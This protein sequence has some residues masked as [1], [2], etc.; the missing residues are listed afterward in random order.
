VGTSPRSPVIFATL[1]TCAIVLSTAALAPL[2][3]QAD[4]TLLNHREWS[5]TKTKVA[6]DLMGAKSYLTGPQALAGSQLNLGAWHGYQEVAL[7]MKVRPETVRFRVWLEENAYLY[8][9]YDR[10]HVVGWEDATWQA[11]R[12]STWPLLPSAQVRA[13]AGGE[14]LEH[15]PLEGIVLREKAWNDVEL[16]FGADTAVLILNKGPA[17]PVGAPILDAFHV[18]FRGGSR[19]A[20]VD[21]IA[22]AGAGNERVFRADFSNTEGLVRTALVIASLLL[23]ATLAFLGLYRAATGGW[24]PGAAAAASVLVT[25]AVCSWI[26]YVFFTCFQAHTYP[27]FDED[28]RRLEDFLVRRF[29]DDVVEQ[30]KSQF[31]PENPKHR[32]RIL[33]LGTSQTWGSGAMKRE[34]AFVAQVE[35]RLNESPDDDARFECIPAAIPGVNA[36]LLLDFYRNFW[37]DFGHELVV[38]N[39]GMNDRDPDAFAE[40]LRGF[41]QLNQQRG[42]P[43]LFALEPA[44]IED[45]PDGL[46][47]SHSVMR[48]VAQETGTPIVDL[49]AAMKARYADGILW[50]DVVHPT[51]FGH[52]CIA[53][54]L[55]PVIRDLL[56][57]APH[58][59]SPGGSAQS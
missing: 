37:I 51:N 4:N 24:R 53:D 49:F 3:H 39:L 52:E 47:P 46:E 13:K 43:T 19:P 27:V 15:R 35:R 38:I 58:P 33:I 54:V 10:D 6:M 30:I 44:S 32:R 18:A 41:V 9:I 42:I 48:R 21:T 20:S 25:L 34:D 28:A 45:C 57:G 12:L 1:H 16:R 8:V 31:T 50:W 23:G 55:A 17:I 2:L 29:A 14:F 56:A 40:A 5:V 59:P 11:V 36:P 7:R 22:I 26:L